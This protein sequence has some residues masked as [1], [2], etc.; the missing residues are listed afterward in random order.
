MQESLEASLVRIRTADSRVVGAGFLVGEHHILTCAHVVSQALGLPTPLSN[1]RKPSSHST[2]RSFLR[3]PFS[4]LASSSG[5]LHSLTD[6]A[7]LR[8]L[9]CKV[10]HP[11]KQR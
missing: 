6:V 7:I 2:S 3:A 9:N 11:P 10:I 5:A 1:H 4:P 8:A